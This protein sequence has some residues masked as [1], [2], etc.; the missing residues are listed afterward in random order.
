MSSRAGDPVHMWQSIPNTFQS[1]TYLCPLE[2]LC[3]MDCT[4][5][6]TL[7]KLQTSIFDPPTRLCFLCLPLFRSVSRLNWTD[8]AQASPHQV[9]I[10]GHNQ[11]LRCTLWVSQTTWGQPHA[12]AVCR[13]WPILSQCQELRPN[14]SREADFDQESLP[15][16]SK[17][18]IIKKLVENF[19]VHANQHVGL[20][21][22]HFFTTCFTICFYW[23]G[24]VSHR[25][26][27][28]IAVSKK[29][30]KTCTQFRRTCKPSCWF[31]RTRF[32]YHFLLRSVFT[33]MAQSL[34]GK[35]APSQSKELETC[36]KFRSTCKPTC[37]FACTLFFF[38]QHFTLP[39]LLAAATW[40]YMKHNIGPE[41]H[42]TRW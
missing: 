35:T 25:K 14:S 15:H 42:Q 10:I 41:S 3:S 34:L 24:T 19:G 11:E 18:N 22:L 4:N 23:N 9:E 1:P 5:A 30:E 39:P 12:I 37:W 33:A 21:V 38:S 2:A 32:F 20:H 6:Y 26:G 28:P 27:C 29:M 7:V 40:N 36:T 16:R 8:G 17:K 13:F 31:A